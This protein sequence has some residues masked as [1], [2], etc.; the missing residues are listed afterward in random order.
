MKRIQFKL[1]KRIFCVEVENKKM[2]YDELINEAQ[3]QLFEQIQANNETIHNIFFNELE[4]V[5]S[6]CGISLNY[7]E[8]KE[9]TMCLQC[10]NIIKGD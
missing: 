2:S 4:V 8:E 6:E 5:C 9:D 1:N 10:S 3:N 7:G